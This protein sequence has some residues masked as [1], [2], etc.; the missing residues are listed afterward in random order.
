MDILKHIIGNIVIF[1]VI[2]SMVITISEIIWYK[3]KRNTR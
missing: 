3:S 2:I 1:S